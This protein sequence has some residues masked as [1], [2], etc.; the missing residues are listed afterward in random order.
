MHAKMTVRRGTLVCN[1][2]YLFK[3]VGFPKLWGIVRDVL[4]RRGWHLHH[5][6]TP[7]GQH[8]NKFTIQLL[9]DDIEQIVDT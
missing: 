2:I 6:Q 3:Q 9:W 8:C 4:S 5:F 7:Q 1:Q